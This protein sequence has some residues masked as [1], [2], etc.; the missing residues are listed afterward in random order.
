MTKRKST[1]SGCCGSDEDDSRAYQHAHE[2]RHEQKDD[3]HEHGHSHKDGEF[4]LKREGIS[5][6]AV[7]ALFVL[8]SI[9][10]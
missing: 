4:S 5:V 3:D 1:H 10:P 8:G 9:F 7:I 2:H 6:G